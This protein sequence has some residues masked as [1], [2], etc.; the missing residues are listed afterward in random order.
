MLDGVA[1]RLGI[2]W[3]DAEAAAVS[4]ATYEDP[5]SELGKAC[6]KCQLWVM[7]S[8]QQ[9]GSSPYED[10]EAKWAVPLLAKPLS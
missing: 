5:T 7:W 8:D 1:K 2:G 9:D 3:D 10:A 6:A 4:C